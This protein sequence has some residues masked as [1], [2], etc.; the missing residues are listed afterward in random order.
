[1]PQTHNKGF[2]LRKSFYMSN[3]FCSTLVALILQMGD[4]AESPFHFTTPQTVENEAPDVG[5]PRFSDISKPRTCVQKQRMQRKQDM[6][7]T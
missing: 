2:F 3:M 6:L 4:D 5:E 7:T 1:M